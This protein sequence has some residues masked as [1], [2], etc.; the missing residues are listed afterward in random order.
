PQSQ[1]K[2]GRELAAE[3]KLL[4]DEEIGERRRL[5]E[6]QEKEREEKNRQQR[7]ASRRERTRNAFVGMFNDKNSIGGSFGMGANGFLMKAVFNAKIFHLGGGFMIGG[8]FDD[9]GFSLANNE[10][11]IDGRLF[12]GDD[13]KLHE[14]KY[15]IQAVGLHFSA[16][17]NFK[18]VGFAV[19]PEL[20]FLQSPNER[21]D[22]DVYHYTGPSDYVYDNYP[23]TLIG[24]TPTV[25][26]NIPFKRWSELWEGDMAV[27]GSVGYTLFPS[28]KSSSGFQFSLGWLVYL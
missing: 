2:A 7:I 15:Y 13:N 25:Y 1:I 11:V 14:A 22:S 27:T 28:I 3:L 21:W 26:F 19:C 17:I 20:F 12:R 6:Q 16:G 10:G 23:H 18:Y 9:R 4:S 24:V 5:V 8:L